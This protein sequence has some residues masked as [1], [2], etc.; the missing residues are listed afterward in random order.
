MP[1]QSPSGTG[2]TT[3]E[4]NLALPN[5]QFANHNTPTGP[6]QFAAG[7]SYNA[8]IYL[9]N[10]GTEGATDACNLEFTWTDNNENVLDVQSYFVN[11]AES[12][13]NPHIL[14]VNGPAVGP[15][16]YIQ[17]NGWLHTGG[18]LVAGLQL[19]QDLVTQRQRHSMRSM[20]R[21]NSIGLGENVADSLNTFPGTPAAPT[22]NGNSLIQ[23]DP[24]GS[25]LAE[26]QVD[27]GASSSDTFLLPM[28]NG[29]V[30]I[31]GATASNTNDMSV[32][33]FKNASTNAFN[34]GQVVVQFTSG[35]AGGSNPGVV[36]PQ[37]FTLPRHQCAIK[38]AN[39]NAGAQLCQMT[40]N[41]M[42]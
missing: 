35:V 13:G 11:V 39:N 15:Q 27:L 19:Y 33:I 17:F 21:W 2:V 30:W 10:S 14:L 28:Y 29:P 26:F 41:A 7:A 34:A 31:G 18:V 37:Q 36:A 1:W 9:Q 20:W 42:E 22:F 8:L 5:M 3:L 40:L 4:N 38:I 32:V 24:T 12:T 25:V 23:G 6:F 16:L